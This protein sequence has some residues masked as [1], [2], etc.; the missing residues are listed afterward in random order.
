MLGKKKKIYILLSFTGTILSRIIRM[1]TKD[2]YCH[3][4]LSLDKEFNELYSFGRL[5]PYNPL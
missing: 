1:Y 2:K 5:N 4:S 3:A